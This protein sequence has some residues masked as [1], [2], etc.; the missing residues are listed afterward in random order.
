MLEKLVHPRYHEAKLPDQRHVI[1][2]L[3]NG[4]MF[5]V[6]QR[7]FNYSPGIPALE[8]KKTVCFIT[9]CNSTQCIV[10]YLQ[11]NSDVVIRR[12]VFGLFYLVSVM[13]HSL[14]KFSPAKHELD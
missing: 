11:K 10:H 3:V 2:V 9:R 13:K 14:S 1:L 7:T 5:V 8:L 6:F 4:E 12:S